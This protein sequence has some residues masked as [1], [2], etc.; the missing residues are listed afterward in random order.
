MS[1]NTFD[2]FNTVSATPTKVFHYMRETH[3]LFIGESGSRIDIYRNTPRK[4]ETSVEFNTRK[5]LEEI[6]FDQKHPFHLFIDAHGDRSRNETIQ[7]YLNHL[8]TFEIFYTGLAST[9]YTIGVKETKSGVVVEEKDLWGKYE[10]GKE[11]RAAYQSEKA[12]FTRK[13][14]IK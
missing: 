4:Y 13:Y 5:E 2:S 11:L 7:N 6:Y 1:L 14:C 3:E 10:K 12:W 8:F 9:P